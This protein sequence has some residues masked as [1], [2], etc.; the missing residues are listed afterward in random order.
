MCANFTVPALAKESASLPSYPKSE[1][2][3]VA[4]CGSR[5]ATAQRPEGVTEQ[6]SEGITSAFSLLWWRQ[7]LLSYLASSNKQSHGELSNRSPNFHKQVP[8]QVGWAPL[9]PDQTH[10]ECGSPMAGQL[11]Q[12]S[13]G[14]REW[15]PLPTSPGSPLLRVTE[16]EYY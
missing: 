3:A 12:Q 8:A 9:V 6:L 10:R 5:R 13:H 11:D 7:W 1:D 14:P 16:G 4:F 2:P 15:H